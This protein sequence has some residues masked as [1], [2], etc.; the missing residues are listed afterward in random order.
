V[1]KEG[2]IQKI[3][4]QS[5]RATVY[6]S[7]STALY[8]NVRIPFS[9]DY[10]AEGCTVLLDD[11]LS[12][13]V[14]IHVLNQPI[15][16][17][18][19]L[20]GPVSRMSDRNVSIPFTSSRT[21]PGDVLHNYPGSGFLGFLQR[22][23]VTLGSSPLSQIQFLGLDKLIRLIGDNIQV[24]GNDVDI[25]LTSGKGVLPTIDA[26]IGGFRFT[27]D[28]DTSLS[29]AVGKL[30]KITMTEEAAYFNVMGLPVYKFTQT[31][32]T[33]GGPLNPT[34]TFT[35]KTVNAIMTHMTIEAKQQLD[36][37]GDGAINISIG[38][39]VASFVG[40]ANLNCKN[41]LLNAGES[42]NAT[43][44]NISL[45]AMGVMGA[46]AKTELINGFLSS[47]TL[48]DAGA[49]VRGMR[50]EIIG[51]GDFPVR[52]LIMTKI[53]VQIMLLFSG[54]PSLIVSGSAA[55]ISG[56]GAWLP[57]AT[58][59]VDAI[60]KTIRGLL[61]MLYPINVSIPAYLEPANGLTPPG[62]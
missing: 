54:L 19:M 16:S 31:P 41:L 15:N 17:S 24:K 47:M 60:N 45:K 43:G 23:I 50:A 9:I 52:G 56:N 7:D 48:T 21:L 42:L 10:I 33:E 53:L 37:V 12:P 26:K 1:L 11:A 4:I 32:D 3:D 20:V 44:Q 28:G 30:L 2:V 6:I 5:R 49:Q 36:I 35:F 8:E 25:N 29:I 57:M 51:K 62:V 13:P 59:Q 38:K 27:T 40:D 39:L 18:E 55:T 61:A 58:G 14:I 22:S 46:K 34:S